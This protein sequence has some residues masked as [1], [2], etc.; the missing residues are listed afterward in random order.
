MANLKGGSFQ[1]QGKDLFH[2]LEAFG[3]PKTK[4]DHLTHSLALGIKRDTM[5]NDLVD[6]LEREFPE[7]GKLNQLLTPEVMDR[8]REERF[9]DLSDSTKETYERTL[10]SIFQGLEE[11]GVDV[12]LDREY[13][14]INVSQL[15]VESTI[16]ER[17]IDNAQDIVFERPETALFKDVGLVSGFRASEIYAVITEP[18]KY[19]KGNTITGVIGKGGQPYQAKTIPHAIADRIRTTEV[20]V[21]E[22]TISNDLGK[23]NIKPH[24]LRYTYARDTYN[25]MTAQ[26]VDPE[27]ARYLL[28]KEL[29]HH[30]P[31][32][33]DYYLKRT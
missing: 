10:S 8:F 23:E 18:D 4:E 29:N 12:H 21:S 2:R 20:L 16:V 25:E 24:D 5:I 26:R 9:A 14:D 1:K 6:F 30:R 33:A 17:Y 22:R 28:S 27:E 31:D 7:G 19:L 3:T 32:M 11:V 15:N 13:F